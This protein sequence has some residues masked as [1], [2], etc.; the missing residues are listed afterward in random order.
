M[1]TTF[2]VPEQVFAPVQGAADE[3]GLQV[4][5]IGE[6]LAAGEQPLEDLLGYVLRV[7]RRRGVVDR[8][9][10][11]RVH[12][13]VTGV[14]ERVLPLELSGHRLPPPFTSN[15]PEQSKLLQD[16]N[17]FFCLFRR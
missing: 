17:A 5:L 13:V 1:V 4:L 11:D 14:G 7:L 2:P 16:K 8:H 10:V 12:I 3:P 9:T 6:A 15:T